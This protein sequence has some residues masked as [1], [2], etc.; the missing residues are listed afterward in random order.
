M[1]RLNP[2][3][4]NDSFAPRLALVYAAFFLA[5]G[6][7][8]PFFP[9]WLAARGLDP[10]AIGFVLAAAQVVRVLGTPAGTRPGET[11]SG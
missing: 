10:A 3:N 1:T 6:W 8:L 2:A 9:V 11:H 7:Y 4:V 5:S